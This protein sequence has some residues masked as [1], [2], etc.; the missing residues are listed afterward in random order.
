MAPRKICGLTNK[1][2]HPKFKLL[3]EIPANRRVS[4]SR[5]V[6]ETQFGYPCM[7][8]Q[9]NNVILAVRP[10][11][12]FSISLSPRASLTPQPT[13]LTTPTRSFRNLSPRTRLTVGLGILAWGAIGL[14]ISDTA[15]KKLGLEPN[16]RDKE[17]LRKMVPKIVVV[18]KD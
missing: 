4:L 18:E 7:N 16:E 9:G 2:D 13:R 10:L 8:H 17:S 5:L 6:H 3:S 12:L 15:E 1:V 14:Y 11:I